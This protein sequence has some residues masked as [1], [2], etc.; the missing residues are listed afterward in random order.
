MTTN[1]LTVAAQQRNLRVGS[2]TTTLRLAAPPV[3]TD[4]GVL[5]LHPW[6]GLND[7]IVRYADRLAAAGFTVAAPDLYEGRVATTIEEADRLS[8]S[9]DEDVADAFVLAALDELGAAIGDPAARMATIGFSMGGAWALWLPAQRREVVATVVYYGSMSG[10]SLSRARTPVLGHF[11]DTDPYEPDDELAAFEAT[12]RTAGREV[13]IR[14]YA[15]T[16]HWFA[17][18]SRDAYVA[19]AAELAF[20]RTVAFLREHLGSGG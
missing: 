17:E 10:P 9:L 2:R 4:A 14:R 7:D 19:E 18:P 20:E 6:W 3:A 1:E 15:G 11:A 12:L 13:E 16:G 5:L 8:S